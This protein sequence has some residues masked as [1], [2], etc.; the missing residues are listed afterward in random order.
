MISRASQRLVAVC[1][2]AAAVGWIAPTPAEAQFRGLAGAVLGGAIAGAVVGHAYR[3]T[4]A[5]PQG[6]RYA[7][8]PRERRVVT[9]AERRER[10][11]RTAE[12]ERT[13]RPSKDSETRA[14]AALA[15]S[16]K[17]QL[18][19]LKSISAAPTLGS[20]GTNEDAARIGETTVDEASRD[21]TAAIQRLIDRFK[22]ESQRSTKEGDITQH[23]IQQA[24]DDSFKK[25]GL[26]RFQ[27]FAGE[28]WSGER[29]RVMVLTRVEGEVGSLL[30]GTNRGQVQMAELAK[31][32]DRAAQ[33]VY[34]RLFETSEFLAANRA[35]TLFFQRL[36]QVHGELA[37]GEL[38]ED[39]EH[40]LVRGA[41]PVA[42][43]FDGLFRRQENGFTLRYRLK[44][45]VFNCLTENV[46]RITAADSGIALRDEIEQRI[47]ETAVGE[48]AA[49][50]SNQF[51]TAEGKL[52]SQEP[53]P[54]RA[55]WSASGPKDEASM[56]GSTSGTM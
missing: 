32:I 51:K 19:V 45:I 15:P 42:A 27:S 12:A 38:G 52:K 22:K 9:R 3:S 53:M 23:S 41:M 48:C 7:A 28:N 40:L 16:S 5:R 24:V 13:E 44:R 1:G 54:L 35:S 34:A 2:V 46:E 6:R 17:Q 31:L 37:N 30:E 26:Q 47:A 25:A 11:E 4:R 20:V 8:P 21:N 18:T 50:A 33:A 56:Y 29:L 49:W 10:G 39:A 43:E 36:Y 14:L 55:G